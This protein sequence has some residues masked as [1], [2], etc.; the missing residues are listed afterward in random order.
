[1]RAL[2]EQLKKDLLPGGF[3]NRIREA[4]VADRDL[5]FSIRMDAFN[6]YY[7][8]NSLLALSGKARPYAVMIHRKLCAPAIQGLRRIQSPQDVSALMDAWPLV[9]ERILRLH[10]GGNEIEFEQMLI[11]ANNREPRML[12]DYLIV[13]RQ[14]T[15]KA[16]PG[17]FDLTGVY[18][19][20]GVWHHQKEVPLALLEI[21]F[22]LNQD[23][24]TIGEQL[25]AYHASIGANIEQVAG[26][27]EVILKQQ[28][29]LGLIAHPPA[30][31]QAF[32]KLR[33]SREV[34]K[35]RFVVVLVD[36]PPGSKKLSQA[37]LSALPFADQVDVTHVGF[38]LWQVNARAVR[39]EQG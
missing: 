8:G 33:I 21:K 3:L 17:R 30:R 2:G 22:G 18:L 37:K 31:L 25:S 9:K 34:S 36:H 23:I 10:T 20:H 6:I 27:S 38:G 15:A 11:R 14:L 24:G 29:D 12:T 16:P 26:E 32:Q 7:K 13:D 5:V 1:M 39:E 35:V 19:E 28:I 4:V